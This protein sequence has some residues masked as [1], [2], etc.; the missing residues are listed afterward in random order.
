[1]HRPTVKPMETCA[2]RGTRET[3]EQESQRPFAEHARMNVGEDSKQAGQRFGAGC[4]KEKRNQTSHRA[5]AS[6]QCFCSEGEMRLVR[7]KQGSRSTTPPRVASTAAFCHA[8]DLIRFALFVLRVER[9]VGFK[10]TSSWSFMAWIAASASG[11]CPKVTNPN[12]RERP[13]PGSVMTM[14]S[15]TCPNC[16]NA[17]RSESLL[18]PLWHTVTSRQMSSSAW[19]PAQ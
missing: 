8:D 13:V 6:V 16:E 7:C 2:Q 9:R 12:P 4:E 18:V 3:G 17:S 1:M 15:I 5:C 14:Q 19:H 10:R 11:C